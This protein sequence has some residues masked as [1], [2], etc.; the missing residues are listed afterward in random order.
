MRA[1]LR[2]L[3]SPFRAVCCVGKGFG[4]RTCRA[5]RLTGNRE[6]SGLRPRAHDKSA[7][8]GGQ[9]YLLQ[10]TPASAGEDGTVRATIVRVL[11]AHR[12]AS[13]EARRARTKYAT[14]GADLRAVSFEDADVRCAFL[15]QVNLN[16]ANLRRADLAEAN[17]ESASLI[18]AD[19]MQ[20]TLHDTDLRGAVLSGASL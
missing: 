7:V 13:D 4:H 10:S 1:W 12:A 6:A 14:T 11:A 15:R 19:L 2:P 17:L 16:D 3:V 18:D 8:I 9:R 20:A 5:E